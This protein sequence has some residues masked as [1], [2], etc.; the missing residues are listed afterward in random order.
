MTKILLLAAGLLLS[1]VPADS[2]LDRAVAKLARGEPAAA[3]E[4]IA[5]GP[6]ALASI[7]PY[8][9]DPKVE[10]R[11]SA[12]LAIAGMNGRGESCRL[13]E[14]LLR[15]AEPE[16][17]GRAALALYQ[18]CA[19]DQRPCSAI[20]AVLGKPDPPAAVILMAGECAS[21]RP[22]LEGLPEKAFA[23]LEPAGPVVAAK[24]VAAVALLRLGDASKAGLLTQAA[25]N[26]VANA[27][28]LVAVLP[29]IPDRHLRAMFPLLSD[30]RTTSRFSNAPAGARPPRRIQDAAADAFA[31]RLQIRLPF[32]EKPSGRY[33]EA[34]LQAARTAI[35]AKAVAN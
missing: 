21:A 13:L 29:E 15:D 9:R 12:V 5:I 30:T 35:D 6:P 17:R 2:Q 31:M 34:E 23:K 32:A 10:V 25:R 7:E 28:L 20:T 11:R 33:T 3:G 27:E 26:T 22:L 19:R 14:V 1:A 18:G 8:L 4:L 16:I 24:L